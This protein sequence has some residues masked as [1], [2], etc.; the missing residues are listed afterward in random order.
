MQDALRACHI[1]C[2]GSRCEF[3]TINTQLL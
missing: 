2:F 1:I 3:G